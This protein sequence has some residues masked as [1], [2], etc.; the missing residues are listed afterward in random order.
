MNYFIGIDIGCGGAKACLVNDEGVVVDRGFA[1]HEIFHSNGTWHESDPEKIFNNICEILRRI[2]SENKIDPAQIRGVSSSS[3][4]PALVMID[5]A[6]NVVNRSYNFMDKRA[7]DM[8]KTVFEHATPEECF[9]KCAWSGDTCINTFILWEKLNRPN[10]YTR[11][12]K[13]LSPDGFVTYRLTGRPV[14]NYS[15]AALYGVGFDIRRRAF[16]E[17]M[18]SRIGIDMEKLP[19]AMPC[20]EVVG[21]IT[22][23]ASRRTG[24]PV[25]VPVVAGT[26]DAYAGWLG[27]GAIEAGD[28]QINLGTAA[29]LGVVGQEGAPFLK[30]TWTGIYPVHSRTSSVYL[31][32]STTGAYTMRFLRNQFSRYERFVESTSG[33]D[34]YDLLNLDAEST[35]PG[36]DGLVT[37]PYL[38]GSG[39]HVKPMNPRATGTVWGM[40]VSH[41]K[42]HLIRSMMEGVAMN[43]MRQ[44]TS[45]EEQ[46]CP[47]QGPIIMNE[48]GAKSRLWR[49]I[50]TDVLG[51]PTAMLQNRTGAPYG[52]AILAGV[53]T[54]YLKDFSVAKEW[55]QYIDY[56]EPD[57]KLHEIH[58]HQCS[59]YAGI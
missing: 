11:V 2:A 34:A 50:Y 45:L 51:R 46:G 58:G 41:T 42:G 30:N 23:E 7:D 10:D 43:T 55:A 20:E 13:M 16:D 44:L 24:I 38:L 56:R 29:V 47:I 27:G 15:I 52:N 36:A 25:G 57:M 31:S 18:C 22:E 1:E 19:E 3:S 6:G 33:Y 54:G 49:K 21:T 9:R 12:W 5:R 35:P 48:G 37:L 26:C 8:Y 59:C 32:S 17:E 4:V 39:P 14:V 53:S 40:D 28:A